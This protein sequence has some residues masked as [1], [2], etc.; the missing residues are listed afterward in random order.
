[1]QIAVPNLTY[2]SHPLK[3]AAP[4]VAELQI[5]IQMHP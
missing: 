3:K 5:E 4:L 2:E 1:M